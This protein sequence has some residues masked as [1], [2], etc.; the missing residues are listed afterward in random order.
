MATR[1]VPSVRGTHSLGLGQPGRLAM[2]LT[3][4]S[5]T[6]EETGLEEG[7]RVPLGDIC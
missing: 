1:Q 6:K 4:Q 5:R 2:R 7:S 3:D